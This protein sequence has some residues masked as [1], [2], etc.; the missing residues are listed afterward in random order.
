M[1]NIFLKIKNKT[2]EFF[3]EVPKNYNKAFSLLVIITFFI[4]LIFIL[5]P[6]FF[7]TFYNCNT[8]DV[9]QYYPYVAGFFEKI[10]TGTL[11][12]YDT[13]L[14]GGTSFFSGTYYVPIDIFLV[15]AFFLSFILGVYRAY[16]ISILFKVICSAYL[17]FYVSKK[18]NIR[19]LVCT[20][21]S[22]VYAFTGLLQAYFVFPVYLGI[23]FYAPLAMI[24]VDM[25]F[26]KK[27]KYLSYYLI[28]IYVLAIVI[29]DYYLA[30]MLLAFMAIYFV[31]NLCLKTT[32]DDFLNHK[33]IIKFVNFFLLIFLGVFI[34]CAILLP[35][36]LYILNETSRTSTKYDN[37]F[38]FTTWS[39]E[40]NANV[41][42]LR[43]YFTQLIN[44]YIPNNPNVFMLIEAGDYVREHATFYMTL[45][46]YVYLIKALTLG[47]KKSNVLRV[48]T[49]AL[50]LMFL[51]PVFSMIFTAQKI[52]YVRWFFIPFIFNLLT[53]THTMDVSNFKLF[54]KKNSKFLTI[55]NTIVPLLFMGLALALVLFTLIK[56]PSYFIHYDANST[57]DYFFLGILIPTVVF[58]VI[59]LLVLILPLCFKRI[60]EYKTYWTKSIPLLVLLELIFSCVIVVIS[61]GS[62]SCENQY[63][64]SSKQVK[65]LRQ[66]TNY[67]FSDGYRIN[68]YTNNKCLA[69]NNVAHLNVNC[70]NFFQ[71]FYNTPLNTYMSD[72]SG[73]STSSWSRRSIY[74]YSLFNAPMFNNKYVITNS[75]SI[76]S[77]YLLDEKVVTRPLTLSGEYYKKYEDYN[78]NSYYELNN[79]PNFIVYDSVY[80]GSSYYVSNETTFTKDLSLLKYGYVALDLSLCTSTTTIDYLVNNYSSFD[81]TLSNDAKANLKSFLALNKAGLVK[82]TKTEA[83]NNITSSNDY[84]ELLLST[85]TK[86]EGSNYFI[87]DLTSKNKSVFDYD[88]I[89]AYPYDSNIASM[90]VSDE[91]YWMYFSSS[92]YDATD[93]LILNPFH[94]NVSYIKDLGYTSQNAPD[95]FYMR[96]RQASNS[97]AVVLY[98]INYDVYEDFINTQAKYTD[99]Y[100]SLDSNKMNIR[101]NNDGEAKVIKT[102]YTYSSDWQIENNTLGYET[103]SINGGFLGIIVPKG[104]TNVNVNLRFI[105]KGYENGFKITEIGVIIYVSIISIGLMVE[106]KNKIG[107]YL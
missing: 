71:S 104:V 5:V 4:A 82:Y 34:S 77:D 66:I 61:V 13:A 83:L 32:M 84:D 50:N 89:Y 6:N 106:I 8:D 107:D 37:F 21:V 11:S 64:T 80:Y 12:I 94:Y 41:I 17:F 76:T 69:N 55:L 2:K 9:I 88:M 90:D 68:L 86:K 57:S 40:K 47:D 56:N 15:L 31:Y 74:G 73:I 53:A 26:S 44:F 58:I 79:I 3:N 100:Y 81:D 51:M 60:R 25:Y 103:V 75:Q 43:H 42:S 23:I 97:N 59:Y 14:F 1:E 93:R 95:K 65:H 63:E 45:G 99:R 105:P 18:H 98:G 28:P 22:I 20:V 48:F 16:F 72:I 52:A 101:F 33:L 39:S 91:R 62:T 78:N 29:F 92:D 67:N 10:K 35:S 87:Y 19:P 96:Y 46:V 27:D 36:A 70:T 24:L 54:E 49:I 85:S 30:Y 102:A 38:Y 7:D